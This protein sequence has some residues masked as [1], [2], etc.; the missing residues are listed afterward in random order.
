MKERSSDT[1]PSRRDHPID[2]DAIVASLAARFPSFGSHHEGREP[3]NPIVAGLRESPPAFA[4][5]VDIR[6]V[7][8]HV[9]KLLY[10]GESQ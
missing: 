3:M 5:G 9:L 6:D 8:D 1:R 10:T 7:V 2:I 4:F